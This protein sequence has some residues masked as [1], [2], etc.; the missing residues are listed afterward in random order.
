MVCPLSVLSNVDEV[1]A[2]APPESFRQL[3]PWA[4]VGLVSKL[5]CKSAS[6]KAK[7]HEGK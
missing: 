7:W 3:L 1:S 4:V 5:G 2:A 6:F